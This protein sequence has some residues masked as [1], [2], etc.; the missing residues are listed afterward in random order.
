MLFIINKIKYE[1]CLT[2]TSIIV[3]HIIFALP[4]DSLNTSLRNKNFNVCI[5]NQILQSFIDLVFF[6]EEYLYSNSVI[7]NKK[8]FYIY[9]YFRELNQ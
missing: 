9:T 7:T 2:N 5:L 6:V 4:N 1:I 3:K 8:Y